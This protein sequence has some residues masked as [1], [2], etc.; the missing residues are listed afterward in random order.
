M[1]VKAG[2]HPPNHETELPGEVLG[3][4]EVAA[5]LS[6]CSRRAPTGI[7]NRTLL[8]LLYR[9]GL[10]ISE[11]LDLCAGD[12]DMDTHSIRLRSTKSGKPQTRGWH[13]HADDAL[14]RWIDTRKALGLRNGRCACLPRP[15]QPK[16]A[17]PAQLTAWR[18]QLPA[19]WAA[20]QARRAVCTAHLFCT[21]QGTPVSDR[22]I[23]DMLKRTATKAGIEHRVHPHA[24]R[25]TFAV[26]LLRAHVP[27]ETISKMLGHSSIAITVRYLDHLTNSEAVAAL[28]IADL[29]PIAAADLPALS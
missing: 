6:Q 19:Q 29:P 27:I 13:P 24:F 14:A 18:A 16:N 15:K 12:L 25:H 5:I 9:S 17:T 3:S 7:R 28:Q 22:Y 10:R 20:W 26:E 2:E 1:P 11:A 23:R 8:T 21:L 4:D